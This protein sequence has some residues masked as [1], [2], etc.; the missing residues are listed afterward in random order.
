[1]YD[2]LSKAFLQSFF[3]T[4]FDIA[5]VVVFLA[6]SRK[7]VCS[8]HIC[9]CRC[10][11]YH[12]NLCN[13]LCPHWPH[14][15]LLSLGNR[16]FER[17]KSM[18]GHLRSSQI[19]LRS[20]NSLQRLLST[21][22]LHLNKCLQIFHG[23]FPASG[24]SCE[25]SKACRKSFWLV[26]WDSYQ[27][28]KTIPYRQKLRILLMYICTTAHTAHPFQCK[29]KMWHETWMHGSVVERSATFPG[30]ENM[31]KIDYTSICFL[32]SLRHLTPTRLC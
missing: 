4:F 12:P 10:C 14:L 23:N 8:T 9:P 13:Q 26:H 18:A 20:W 27:R 7:L 32:A 24:T 2:T 21:K 11:T 22:E 5:C 1:M 17:Q 3:E 19:L 28:P 31:N 6:V 25:W 15:H 29:S 16:V 30:Q